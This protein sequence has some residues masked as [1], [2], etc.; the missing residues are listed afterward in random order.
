[1]RIFSVIAAFLLGAYVSYILV[2]VTTT[3]TIL[4]RTMMAEKDCRSQTDYI[5]QQC[6]TLINACNGGDTDESGN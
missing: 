6:K 1:M 5:K 4:Q 2:S 3:A